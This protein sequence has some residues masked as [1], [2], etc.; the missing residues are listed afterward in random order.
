M[1]GESSLTGGVRLS[2]EKLGAVR[3]GVFYTRVVTDCSSDTFKNSVVQHIFFLEMDLPEPYL[4]HDFTC[5][6]I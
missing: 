3:V 1:F 5:R 6:Y 2:K 4:G